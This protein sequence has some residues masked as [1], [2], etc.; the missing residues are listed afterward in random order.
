MRISQNQTAR[1]PRVVG[2][3]LNNFPINNNLFN[4]GKSYVLLI[5]FPLSMQADFISVSPNAIT[6]FLDVHIIIIIGITGFVNRNIA[7]AEAGAINRASSPVGVL[8]AIRG[9]LF[10]VEREKVYHGL[11]TAVSPLELWSKNGY[12]FYAFEVPVIGGY[13]FNFVVSHNG[14]VKRIIGKQ[15]V[16]F[17]NHLGSVQDMLIEWPYADIKLRDAVYSDMA[18]SKLF[19]YLRVGFQVRYSL[20]WRDVIDLDGFGYHHSMPD[21]RYYY[22]GS[23]PNEIF[24]FTALEKICGIVV[25][26]QE[27]VDKNVRVYKKKKKVPFSS[28]RMEGYG[29][30]G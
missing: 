7:L 3:F 17:I 12:L 14:K 4:I 20:T 1:S 26:P 5:S 16:P 8:V 6:Q 22:G 28:R 2:I 18:F 9:G 24:L 29:K 21:L 10:R 30:C 15:A 25:N 11:P 19:D 23:I 13:G 27:V